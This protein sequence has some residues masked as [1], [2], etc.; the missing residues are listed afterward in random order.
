MV[1]D[2]IDGKYE[3]LSK[4]GSGGTSIVYKARRL[5]DGFIVAIKVVRDELED[6]DEHERHFRHEAE[7]LAK[8]SHRNV[9]RILAVGQWNGSLYMVTE[10]ID[11]K[12][13]KDIIAQNGPLPPKKA[14]D[15]ALQIAAGIEHAHMKNIIH[16]DI[17]PQN[18]LVSN[19]GTVKIVDFGIARVLS[20]Q[21]T[22]TMGGKDVVG[23]VHYISP[24]QARG[25]HVDSRTDI[26]SFGVLLYEM[27]TG[28]VPFE[29]D[30]AVSIAM[31]HVNQMPEAPQ[32]VNP[33]ISKGINDIILKCMQKDP[34]KRYQTASELREDLLLYV[35]NPEGFS[36]IGQEEYAQRPYE[37]EYAESAEPVRRKN[38]ITAK[39]EDNGGVRKKISYINEEERKKV[40]ASKRKRGLIIGISV[41]ASALVVAVVLSIVLP[42]VLWGNNYEQKAVPTVTDLSR[43][44]AAAIMRSESFSKFRYVEENSSSVPVDCVIRTEP[45]ARSIVPVNTEIVIYISKGAKQLMAENTIGKPY[46]EATEILE[47][48]GFKVKYVYIEDA[49]KETGT[50]A[51]QSSY[52]QSIAEGTEITLTIVRNIAA[53]EIVVPDLTGLSLEDAKE[54]IVRAGFVVG[55][56]QEIKSDNPDELG[57]RWQNID[58]G[59]QY[60]YI[61]GEEPPEVAIDFTVNI[62]SG[63]R[64]VYEYTVPEEYRAQT[65]ELL[66]LN[67]NGEQIDFRRYVD[68]AFIT[69]EYTSEQMENI[70]FE[71][72]FENTQIDKKVLTTAM[73]APT[74]TPPAEEAADAWQ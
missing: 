2:I 17:K 24:E 51:D 30:E 47:G 23:S 8:M 48:Q 28:R 69:L 55:N 60:L 66:V 14:V 1:N 54:A 10:Y 45:E 27:F 70:T 65:L 19:D 63:Y 33:A 53:L 64:C 11:G 34:A 13:L 7:A 4:I 50:V 18:I 56:Y 16:R 72:Y 29:G 12:T 20:P 46:M 6:I 74:P 38:I 9:R 40:K 21:T 57:V 3:I 68:A 42:R 58:P 62:S 5:S 52:N 26:Y 41:V 31:K 43:S 37:E 73:N 32:S 44:A 39:E 35:A 59:T 15:Y 49:S 22:R 25:S 67:Q 71:L 61:E 36:V